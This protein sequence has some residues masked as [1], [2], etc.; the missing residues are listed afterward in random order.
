[1]G[2]I[3]DN[4]IPAFQAFAVAMVAGAAAIS[5]VYLTPK[6]WIGVTRLTF[7][8]S[9]ADAGALR[10]VPATLPTGV[11]GYGNTLTISSTDAQDAGVLSVIVV[12]DLEGMGESFPVIP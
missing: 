10:A 7:P 1:M 5:D 6:S 8:V 3:Q 9:A 4:N 2:V 11:D 12:T